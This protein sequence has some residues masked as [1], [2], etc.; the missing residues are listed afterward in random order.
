MFETAGSDEFGGDAA[1]V[2]LA[3]GLDGLASEDRAGWSSGARSARVREIGQLVEGLRAELVRAVSV[4]DG[5]G[6]Y[7]ADGSLNA[8]VWLTHRIPTTRIAAARLVT[9]ARVTRRCERVEKALAAGDV[10][11]SHVETIARTIHNR[12]DI[13]V[14]HGDVLVDAAVAVAPEPF[15]T[16]ARRWRALADDHVGTVDDPDDPSR[17][18]LTLSPTLGGVSLRGWF[19]PAMGLEIKALIDGYDHPDPT[20]GQTPPRTKAQRN[21]AALHALLFGE[22]DP[23]T[24]NVDITIDATIDAQTLA[25][26]WPTNLTALRCDVDGYGPVPRS[27]IRSWLTEAVLRRVVLADS[28][29]LDLGHGVR[30][31]SRAQRRAL[32]HRDGGCV[33]PDCPRPPNW[34]DAHHL[35]A[36][37]H[38]GPTNLHN[39]ALVCRR[40]HHMLEHGW[41]LT[42]HPQ[43]TWQF[44]PPT[45]P[46][47][48]RGPPTQH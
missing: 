27:L 18:E 28:E 47:P 41:T 40:H 48:T 19:N 39:L 32:K 15:L 13:F 36:Y 11:V 2:W 8:T 42:Q 22:R 6:D 4:W 25:G 44:N 20:R 16:V 38:G 10:T 37:T 34:T 24:K 12:E 17:N 35:I 21:A 43:N 1:L 31:A 30:L 3:A 5:A 46:N 26:H 45:D 9:A 33:V 23:S 7:A 14:S 29:V